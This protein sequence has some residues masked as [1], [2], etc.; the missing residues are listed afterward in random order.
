MGENWI[1]N[2]TRDVRFA[3]DAWRLCGMHY[4]HCDHR[5]SHKWRSN[6]WF[7]CP[8]EPDVD[9]RIKGYQKRR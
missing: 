3:C 4:L 8:Y 6:C 7:I 5:E 2:P 1:K 9:G